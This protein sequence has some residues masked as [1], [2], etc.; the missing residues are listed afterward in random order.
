MARF[1]GNEFTGFSV[2]LVF[3]GRYFVMEPGNPPLMIRSNLPNSPGPP[4][5]V[6]ELIAES[7]VDVE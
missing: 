6:D 2:P 5:K 4:P 1:G 7:R 3:E